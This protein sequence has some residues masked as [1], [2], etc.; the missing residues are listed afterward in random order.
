MRPPTMVPMTNPSSAR[1][2]FTNGMVFTPAM[3]KPMNRRLPVM[4]PVKT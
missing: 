1:E 2:L 3:A 4:L